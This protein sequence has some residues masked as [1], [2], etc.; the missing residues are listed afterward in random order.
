MYSKFTPPTHRLKFSLTDYW[1]QCIL[2]PRVNDCHRRNGMAQPPPL[3]STN[4]ARPPLLL[5]G[6]A[7]SSPMSTTTSDG[8]P[9]SLSKWFYDTFTSAAIGA[10]PC[11]FFV[12]G[13]LV[14]WS[15]AMDERGGSKIYVVRAAVA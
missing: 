11:G 13:A 4:R 5:C 1:A 14:S 3:L 7:T 9:A 15:L 6:G 12:G 8:A 10:A 2:D